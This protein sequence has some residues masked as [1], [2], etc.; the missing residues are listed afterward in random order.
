MTV[1]IFCARCDVLTVSRGD[2]K[3]KDL[4]GILGLNQ[5]IK[6][7]GDTI[8]LTN[9]KGYNLV[10]LYTQ[11]QLRKTIVYAKLHDAI[12]GHRHRPITASVTNM[13][14]GALLG[15]KVTTKAKSYKQQ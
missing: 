12:V 15:R 11:L 3:R 5:W 14:K 4:I 1:F 7:K 13:D 8:N 10:A 9:G 2:I 6:A